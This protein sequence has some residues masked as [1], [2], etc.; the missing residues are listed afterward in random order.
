MEI[1]VLKPK[2]CPICGKYP[3]KRTV[4]EQDK[5]Y[6][7]FVCEHHTDTDMKALK[8]VCKRTEKNAIRAW[9][10]RFDE[11]TGKVSQ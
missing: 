5:E 7:Y 3:Q 4:I 6:C 9:N 11:N 2:R 10:W 1:E 8:T